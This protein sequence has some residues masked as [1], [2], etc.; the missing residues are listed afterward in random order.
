MQQPKEDKLNSV[1]NVFKD[2]WCQDTGENL[3]DGLKGLVFKIPFCVSRFSSRYMQS[4]DDSSR[5]HHKRRH[6]HSCKVEYR[7]FN[8][9]MA[10]KT[11]IITTL[12]A[13]VITD[14]FIDPGSNSP[15]SPFSFQSSSFSLKARS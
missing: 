8:D 15:C 9:G 12:R 1:T 14:D 5:E 11:Y 7:C 10:T 3:R 13:I 4:S 6:I 2:N